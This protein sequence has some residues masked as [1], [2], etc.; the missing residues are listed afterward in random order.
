[1]A[2]LGRFCQIV[3]NTVGRSLSLLIIFILTHLGIIFANLLICSD[4][5][6]FISM[7]YRLTCHYCQILPTEPL[8]HWYDLGCLLHSRYVKM[9]FQDLLFKM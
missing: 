4:I 3:W 9:L 2:V 6:Y 8:E 7:D 5:L 1:M